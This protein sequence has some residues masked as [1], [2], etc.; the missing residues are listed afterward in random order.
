MEIRRSHLQAGADRKVHGLEYPELCP[1]CG[2]PIQAVRFGVAFTQLQ[3]LVI[4][5]IKQR[6]GILHAD[7]LPEKNPHTVY[8]HIH[9]INDKLMDS[10]WRIK[11]TRGYG[12]RLV[13][14]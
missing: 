13:K 8:A 1:C 6:P 7:I 3:A 4:D 5:R 11:G 12:Y 2:R 9:Q 10:G 14:T